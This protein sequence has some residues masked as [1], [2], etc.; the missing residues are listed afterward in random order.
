MF[1]SLT[2]EGNVINSEDIIC[3]IA[4]IINTDNW[5]LKFETNF[6][7]INSYLSSLGD[8]DE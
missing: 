2:D 1:Y 8:V 4:N 7:V 5:Y 6:S 3:E